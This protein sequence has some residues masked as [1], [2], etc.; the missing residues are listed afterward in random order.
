M[1]L[2]G[3]DWDAPLLTEQEVDEAE[4]A[5]VDVSRTINSFTSS[6]YT[7]LQQLIDPVS[8]SA[9]HGIDQY[10]FA[11]RFVESKLSEY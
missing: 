7:E 6:D 8:E 5:F 1:A 3:I 4:A 2:Y 9:N 11:V 10:L